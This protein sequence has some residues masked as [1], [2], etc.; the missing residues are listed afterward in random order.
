MN[1][2]RNGNGNRSEITEE[3]KPKACG[4]QYGVKD[5]KRNQK[6]F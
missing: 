1:R 3:V 6:Q 2:Q 4:N 5:E